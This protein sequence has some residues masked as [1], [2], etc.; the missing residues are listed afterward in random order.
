MVKKVKG[1]KDSCYMG[2]CVR[3]W[4]LKIAILGVLVLL[5]AYQEYFPWPV[6]WGW[7]LVLVG[8]MKLIWPQGPHCG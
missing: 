1:A 3:C 6:F 5:N 7:I 8:I 2:A 4:G